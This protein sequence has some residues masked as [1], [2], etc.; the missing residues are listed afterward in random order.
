MKPSEDF[1]VIVVGGGVLVWPNLRV[2]VE[3]TAILPA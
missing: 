2:E 1:D 3:V